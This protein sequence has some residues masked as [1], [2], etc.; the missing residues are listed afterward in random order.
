M[1]Q[2]TA[3]I[4]RRALVSVVAAYD[5]SVVRKSAIE[6]SEEF[7]EFIGKPVK[8]GGLDSHDIIGITGELELI[9]A[10]SIPDSS[11]TTWGDYF[12]HLKAELT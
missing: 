2:A 5:T 3:H 7:I 1:A 8:C 9:L 6:N 4:A 11:F 10:V 12:N